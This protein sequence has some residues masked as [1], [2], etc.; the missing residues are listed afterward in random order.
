M[1]C[2]ELKLLFID[3]TKTIGTATIAGF[4]QN[5]PQYKFENKHHSV[6]NFTAPGYWHEE[7]LSRYHMFMAVRNPYDRMVSQWLWMKK[8]PGL[9]AFLDNENIDKQLLQL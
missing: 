4:Q 5:Y 2:H 9:D 1:I 8:S 6:K 7:I 3:I